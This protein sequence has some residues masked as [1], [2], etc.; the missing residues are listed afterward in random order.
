MTRFLKKRTKALGQPPGTLVHIGEQKLDDV[1]VTVYHYNAGMYEERKVA[2]LSECEIYRSSNEVV[3]IDV[4]GLHN[5]EFLQRFGAMFDIHELTLEDIV[6]TDQ[7]PKVEEYANYLYVSV[8]ML[9]FLPDRK[10]G[11]EQVSVVLKD[12]IVISFQ[13]NV[14]DIFNPVRDELRRARGRVRREKADFLLYTLLDKIV[15][16]Y[17]VLMEDI[18]E[19]VEMLEDNML[20]HPPAAIGRQI[21]DL[22]REILVLR[23]SV[24]PMRELMNMLVRADS[25]CIQPSTR[26]FMQD[27]YDHVI[28]VIETLE[29]FRELLSGTLDVYL[30]SAGNRLNEVMKV[31]TIIATIFIPLTFVVGVYG[32]NFHYMPELVW[33]WGYPMTWALMLCIAG[34]MIFFFKRKG[35]M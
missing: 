8:K 31:L 17:F 34:G 6:N 26:M 25:P 23:R 33:R 20:G 4:N 13:E 21:N 16:H 30:T 9:D 15:D 11:V 18:G 29:I 10:I 32:M 3:W 12:N 7:R 35:W 24:W 2:T 22:K 14:G 5:T 19:R 27:V 1:V 28:H